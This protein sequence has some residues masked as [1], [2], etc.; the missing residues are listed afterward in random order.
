MYNRLSSG[1]RGL[2]DE[3]IQ[4]V[5]I[6]IQVAS[7]LPS[8]KFDGMFRCPCSMLKNQAFLKLD[9]VKVDLYHRVFIPD[10]WIWTS[11]GEYRPRIN[12]HAGTSITFETFDKDQMSRLYEELIFDVVGPNL[13]A[14]VEDTPNV[15]TK[16]FF[17][18]LHAA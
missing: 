11:H 1:R 14:S 9:D 8:F 3:L 4:G 10:Y 6:F 13:R 15:E 12:T 5:E 7:Q 2:T 18:L 16:I 17:E